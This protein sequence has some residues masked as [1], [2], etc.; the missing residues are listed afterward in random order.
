M[1]FRSPTLSYTQRLEQKISQL[2]TALAEA[3]KLSNHSHVNDR[4]S[5]QSSVSDVQPHLSTTNEN[6]SLKENGSLSFNESISLFQSPSSIRTLAVA[7]NHADQEIASQKQSLVNSAWR[8]RAYE[9]L[10]D[11][12][13][14]GTL[15]LAD[16]KAELNTITGAVSIAA[17]FPL[18]LD[19]TALQFCVPA[20]IHPQVILLRA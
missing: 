11:T 2:E 14:G 8:E 1:F 4:S 6:S 18:L 5:M 16:Y 3:R 7:G 20:S 12:P 19:S 9:R 10:A 15:I 13:V 17:G